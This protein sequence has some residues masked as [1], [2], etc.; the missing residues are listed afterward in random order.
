[1]T[2]RY[3]TGHTFSQ[4]Q[5]RLIVVLRTLYSNPDSTANPKTVSISSAL[6][7]ISWRLTTTLTPTFSPTLNCV[8]TLQLIIYIIETFVFFFGWGS[9]VTTTRGTHKHT[10]INLVAK[11]CSKLIK[12]FLP[13]SFCLSVLLLL[14]V[15]SN[16]QILISQQELFDSSCVGARWEIRM[17]YIECVCVRLVLTGQL[18]P[19]SQPE[20]PVQQCQLSQRA[21]SVP[22]ATHNTHKVVGRQMSCVREGGERRETLGGPQRYW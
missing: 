12:L 18:H 11:A 21:T 14:A 13:V 4:V 19:C 8:L 15:Y 16:E 20:L 22:T 9:W 3:K 7:S 2:L 5:S 17:I 6:I 10:V 1:M